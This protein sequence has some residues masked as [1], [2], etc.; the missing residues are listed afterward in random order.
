MSN[1]REIQRVLA[2]DNAAIVRL[3]DDT[4]GLPPIEDVR[5]FIVDAL[6]YPP[7]LALLLSSV[8]VNVVFSGDGARRI[9]LLHRDDARALLLNAV[10]EIPIPKAFCADAGKPG[11]RGELGAIVFLGRHSAATHAKLRDIRR[12]AHKSPRALA[13]LQARS[14]MIELASKR[15]PSPN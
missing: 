3:I 14:S 6:N 4:T 2:A 12:A 7:S 5:V 10:T 1:D 15:T 11:A 9:F 8:G 13:D